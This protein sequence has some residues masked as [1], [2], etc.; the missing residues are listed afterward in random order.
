[1]ITFEKVEKQHIK[2]H[3]TNTG[4]YC[5]NSIVSYCLQTLSGIVKIPKSNNLL[6]IVWFQDPDW[7]QSS[8]FFAR[9]AGRGGPSNA[10]SNTSPPTQTTT[11]TNT[12]STTTSAATS[13][14]NN[15]TQQETETSTDQLDPVVLKS[16]QLAGG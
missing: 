16:R 15:K 11:K 7:D 13:P 1:M 10:T 3:K 6:I 5:I 4:N 12:Q 8:A 9:A 14:T 2:I